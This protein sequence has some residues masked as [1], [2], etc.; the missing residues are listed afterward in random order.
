VSAPGSA[1]DS[2]L[3]IED[4]VEALGG[5]LKRS[6]DGIAGIIPVRAEASV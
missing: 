2:V 5:S 3:A 1:S 6:V 4:R